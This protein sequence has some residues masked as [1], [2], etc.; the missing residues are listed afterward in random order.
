MEEYFGIFNIVLGIVFILT[1]LKILHPFNKEKEQELLKKFKDLYAAF[2][3]GGVLLIGFGVLKMVY[4][5]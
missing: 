4:G 3:I 5:F 1:G 2:T